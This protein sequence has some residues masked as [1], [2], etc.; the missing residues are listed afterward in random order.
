MISRH[1]LELETLTSKTFVGYFARVRVFHTLVE[2]FLTLTNRQCQIVNLGA[3]Y[4]TLYWIL[5]QKSILPKLFVEVD[6][7]N[8]T[9]K[10]CRYIRYT[11]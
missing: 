8:I 4:D 7:S 9:T 3:G 11:K 1:S 2:E 5:H 6:F 10:K